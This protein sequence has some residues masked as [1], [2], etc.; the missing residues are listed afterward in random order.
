VCAP[1]VCCH[2][3]HLYNLFLNVVSGIRIPPGETSTDLAVLAAIASSVANVPLPPGT[4]LLGE[5]GLAGELRQ[6]ANLEVR[7][8]AGLMI[9]ILMNLL[10]SSASC[11][12]GN[13]GAVAAKVAGNQ[14]ADIQEH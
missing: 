4:A 10:D 8:E 7:R 6:V 3:S 14:C 13:I 11:W 9:R 1:A 2:Q 12:L 5:V